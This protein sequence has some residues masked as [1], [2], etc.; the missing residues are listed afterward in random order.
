MGLPH[1]AALVEESGGVRDE[2]SKRDEIN[3]ARK[4]IGSGDG[5]WERKF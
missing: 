4:R 3:A 2:R 5:N 1:R